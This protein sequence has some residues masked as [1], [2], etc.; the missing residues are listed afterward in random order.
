MYQPGAFYEFSIIS[1]TSIFAVAGFL[2]LPHTGSLFPS[3]HYLNVMKKKPTLKKQ[4]HF[5]KD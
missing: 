1:H 4:Q 2:L 3:S 5:N